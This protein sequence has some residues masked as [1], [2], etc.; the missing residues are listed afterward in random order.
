MERYLIHTKIKLL[1]LLSVYT[2]HQFGNLSF[3]IFLVVVR[4][5]KSQ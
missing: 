5:K 2:R 1:V 4:E 3:I